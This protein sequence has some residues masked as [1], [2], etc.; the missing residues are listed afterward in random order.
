MGSPFPW[1]WYH[2]ALLAAAWVGAALHAGLSMRRHGRRWWVWFLIC[3]FLTVIPA[4]VVSYLDYRRQLQRQ[5]QAGGA[6]LRCPH[7]GNVVPRRE[8]RRAGGSA[9]CPRCD[10]AIHNE[11]YA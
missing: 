10:M 4:T 7:C 2:L 9:V 11:H 1:A 8:L 5:H 6:W 3:V